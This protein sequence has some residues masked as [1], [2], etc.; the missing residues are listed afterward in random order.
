MFEFTN[1]QNALNEY[2]DVFIERY[3][4][5]LDDKDANASGT[6]R[7]T[8]TSNVL[9][10]DLHYEVTLNLQGYYK[11]VQNGAGPGA[12]IPTDKLLEWINIRR[13]LP[14]DGQTLE[15]MARSIQYSIFKNGSKGFR[16]HR[17]NVFNNTLDELK[18]EYE[19]KIQEALYTDIVDHID[20]L[21]EKYIF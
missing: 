12:F 4:Q 9:V 7:N 21:I 19:T 15:Q 20:E 5:N 8:I 16:E 13:I 10:D 6:L 14:R 18:T 1:L 17:E 11:F 3:Q 2:A